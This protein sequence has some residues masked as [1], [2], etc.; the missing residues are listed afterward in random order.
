MD[1]IFIERINEAY[2]RVKCDPSISFELR[3]YF[4]FKV[5]N[6]W[7]MPKF[8]NKKWDGKIKLFNSL[9]GAIYSGLL[10][11][12]EEFCRERKYDIEYV[13]DFADEEFSTKEALDFIATLNL[14]HVPHEHQVNAF[15][16]CVRKRRALMLSPTGSGKS[17][18]AYILTRYYKKK[19][20]IVVP[21]TGLVSQMQNDFIEYGL[22]ESNIHVVFSGKEKNTELPITITTWQSIFKLPKEWFDQYNLIIGDEAD[23]FDAKSL[24]TIMTNLQNC[25]YRF[26]LTGTLSGTALN[27]TTLEGLFG[28]FHRVA[29]TK[30]LIEKEILSNF[31]VKCVVLNHPEEF[32]ETRP[33]IEELK[34]IFASQSRNRFVKNLALSMKGNTLVLFDYVK[35]HGKPLYEMIKAEAGDRPVYF[36]YGGVKG[37][38]RNEI[39]KIIETEENAIVIASVVFVR[40]INIQSLQNLIFTSPTKAQRKV[41][42]SIGRILRKS[43][44]KDMAT[45]VDIADNLTPANRKR[46]KKNFAMRHF[47][48]R[49]KMYDAEGFNHKIY[50]VALRARLYEVG[51]SD[52]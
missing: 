24:I 3:D 39:R 44:R 16:H 45:L 10:P 7:H 1:T 21:T 29:T 6:H 2:I 40:G 4:T 36:V 46:G 28:I 34:F 26:G 43:K 11:R 32:C 51:F 33:Y 20:L 8:R 25:K 49:L 47:D 42:Q 12:I 38:E 19:T 22:D 18:I 23:G 41:L 9:T 31:T 52:G 14:P 13:H 27:K 48:E 15:V 5:A 17:L 35:R 50:S 37:E 30:E